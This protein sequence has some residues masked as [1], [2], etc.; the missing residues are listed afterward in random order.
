MI[1]LDT[2]I[3]SELFRPKP[4][5]RALEWIGSC[6]PEDLSLCAP[7]L[8]ELR[9][10]ACILPPGERKEVLMAAL[11]RLELEFFRSR[12]LPFDGRAARAFGDIVAER[13][14][15]GKPIMAMDA[16][17]AAIARS[18]GARI[19]TRNVR[20]FEGL[21]LVLFNPFEA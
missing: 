6:P 19:A 15:S 10:G 21:D 14:S 7:V 5:L 1:I 12:V 4:E 9:Q 17:I 13:R 20:D 8:A 18:V 16:Q 2:N 3:V 11:I